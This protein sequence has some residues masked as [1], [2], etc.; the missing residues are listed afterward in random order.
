MLEQF[1]KMFIF[2]SFSCHLDLNVNSLATCF[3][4]EIVKIHEFF[5]FPKIIWSPNLFFLT[6]TFLIYKYIAHSQQKKYI[7][8]PNLF[9]LTETILIYKKKFVHSQTNSR[10]KTYF[11]NK[12]RL[13]GF[14]FK[15]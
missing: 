6:E 10:R 7:W 13:L 1:L 12:I 14:I 8:I 15:T 4:L 2:T 5:L 11:S 9:F 3:S